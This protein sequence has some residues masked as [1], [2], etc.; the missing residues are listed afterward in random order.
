MFP[1]LV[2]KTQFKTKFYETI[3][4]SIVKKLDE[5][6]KS[7]LDPFFIGRVSLSVDLS[8][9]TESDEEVVTK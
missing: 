1:T 9:W 7:I 8:T 2:W 6:T 4:K 3:N 5:M